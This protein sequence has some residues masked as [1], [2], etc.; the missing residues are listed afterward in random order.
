MYDESYRAAAERWL[1]GL[2]AFVP[3]TC[4]CTYYWEH[5]GDPPDPEFHMP[6]WDA[7]ERTHYQMYETTSEGTP[8]SPVFAD[9]E[10]LARWLA[11]TGA[12]AFGDM[13]ATYEQWL[14]TCRRGG[15]VSAAIRADGLVSGVE[16]QSND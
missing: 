14:A 15:A 12:S 3:G 11:D 8:I 2:R 1:E 7:S 9:V 6:E 16:D 13:T 5:S 10:S 4:D